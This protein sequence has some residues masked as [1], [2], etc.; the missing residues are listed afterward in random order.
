MKLI[1]LM[2]FVVLGSSYHIT[3]Q[4]DYQVETNSG[5]HFHFGKVDNSSRNI[6]R[7][8][9]PKWLAEF[10]G[11][12]E[13]P[14]FDPPYIP[15]DFIN[16]NSVPKF[17]AHVQGECDPLS[18]HASCSFDCNN[19]VSYD[20]I[21]TCSTLSQTF[22]DGPSIATLKLLE[23]LPHPT[24]FFTLGVNVIRYPEIYKEAVS[25]GHIMGSH[26]WSHKFLPALTN[27]QVVAQIEWSIWAMNATSGHLPKW[28]RPP[29]GGVDDRIR[30]I[31]RQFGMQSVLWD[32]DTNDWKLLNYQPESGTTTELE[33]Y[34]DLK[35]F[36]AER[37]RGL[38]LE[39]DVAWKTVD[40]AIEINNRILHDVVQ[41][42]VP[43]CARGKDYIKVFP[44][45][46]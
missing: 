42:T 44:L 46:R 45:D 25:K 17:K 19:C 6:P 14:G 39:H 38:I 28:F 10:T 20:D 2:A 34:R 24:T 36:K 4:S 23:H 16:L 18:I 7:V 1:I 35:K 3:D 43:Q 29:Y 33:I 11:L 5:R 8:P 41:Q 9:F 15:L 40:V 12:N 21:Y 31:V 27:Q 26:T 30:S 22:D 13:W 37:Q 32:F